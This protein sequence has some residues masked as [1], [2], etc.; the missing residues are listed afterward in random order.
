MA[1][2][3]YGPSS[4]AKE[5]FSYGAPVVT[6]VSPSTGPASGQA[7]GGGGGGG[8]DFWVTVTGDNFGGASSPKV[9]VEFDAT[10]GLYQAVKVDDTDPVGAARVVFC[11]G[12]GVG[13]GEA[14]SNTK[15]YSV[16]RLKDGD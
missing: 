8:G 2:A 10:S 14:G 9:L 16:V 13:S 5:K 1:R 3:G 4:C 12:S 11:S 7:P 15:L 6:A